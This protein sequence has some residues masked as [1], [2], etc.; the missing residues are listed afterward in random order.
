MSHWHCKGCGVFYK[1][2]DPD[3]VVRHVNDCD[4][5]DGTGA[6]VTVQL[7]IRSVSSYIVRVPAGEL[8]AAFGHPLGELTECSP[9]EEGDFD[10]FEY[11]TA[12]IEKVSGRAAAPELTV[13]SAEPV[14]RPVRT[15]EMI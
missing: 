5:V 12:Q 6:P 10:L 15:E 8:A 2:A 7:V 4:Y 11:L 9:D 3:A 13:I 14:I 1:N